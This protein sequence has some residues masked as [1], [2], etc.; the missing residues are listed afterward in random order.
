MKIS[1]KGVYALRLML[2]IAGHEPNSVVSLK[3][4]SGRQGISVKYL[5]QIVLTLNKSEFLKRGRGVQGWYMLTRAPG[6]YT[7]GEVLRAAEGSLAPI[8]CLQNETNECEH[9]EECDTLWFWEGLDQV[10]AGY[11]DR[12]TL[13]DLL[14]HKKE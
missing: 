8:S 12:F 4:I 7:V 1:T 5:Q 11:V 3:E 9:C 13:Q 6:D 2:D 10:I 14:D